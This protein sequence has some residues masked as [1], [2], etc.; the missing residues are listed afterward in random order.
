MF[1]DT[2]TLPAY[3]KLNWTL[4]VLGRRTD[5][6]HELDTIFQTVTLHDSITFKSRSDE[7][8]TL[9]SDATDIPVDASNLIVR[10]AEELRKRYDIRQGAAV[11][12]EKR[13]PAAG[14]LGGGSSDA[15]VTLLGLAHLWQVETDKREL[16]EIGARLGADVPFFLTGGTARG[17]GLG[18]EV[19]ALP[20]AP[21]ARL[22]IV[23]PQAQVSTAEAYKALSAPALTK[24]GADI[25]LSSSRP[26]AQFTDSLPESLLNDFEPVIYRLQPEI[27]R[28]RDALLSAGARVALLAGSGASVFG[29]FEN[30]QAQE[31]AA[32]VL[33][34][35]RDWRVFACATLSRAS[36]VQQLGMCAAPLHRGSRRI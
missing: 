1:S 35:E 23:K 33:S 4:R 2:F 17:T 18:T 20:D 25:I 28:A 5:G 29:L 12:L 36:Y 11:H 9:T 19:S 26:Q 8:I 3:A 32:Q 30:V 7:R 22:V 15:A 31:H 14:G 34:S 13:I 16:E 27:L 21:D 6:Y 24:V 10:A